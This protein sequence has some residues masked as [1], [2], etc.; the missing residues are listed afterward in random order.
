MLRASSGPHFGADSTKRCA[1][2]TRPPW[3][4]SPTKAMPLQRVALAREQSI[5]R[6]SSRPARFRKTRGTTRRSASASAK[7]PMRCASE[8]RKDR[9]RAATAAGSRPS[10][11]LSVENFRLKATSVLGRAG[12]SA[13]SSASLETRQT[14]VVQRKA[15][16]QRCSKL[17]VAW[18]G[19]S[20]SEHNMVK[21]APPTVMPILHNGTSRAWNDCLMLLSDWPSTTM[22]K[23]KPKVTPP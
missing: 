13:T 3:P 19:S 20:A 23:V 4:A 7:R 17:F 18:F 21:R 9:T 22:W 8:E 1:A 15:S 16:A 5:S 2:A 14:S 11:S 6:A 10:S 12:A